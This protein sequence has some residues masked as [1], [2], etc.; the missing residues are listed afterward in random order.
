MKISVSA[1]RKN[2]PDIL[3]RVSRDQARFVVVSRGKPKAA[4][5]SVEDLK[6][7]DDLESALAT[8]EEEYGRDE[9]IPWEQIEAELGLVEPEKPAGRVRRARAKSGQRSTR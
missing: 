8:W 2:L 5:V 7:L 4:I 1:L 3:N 6:I 9:A